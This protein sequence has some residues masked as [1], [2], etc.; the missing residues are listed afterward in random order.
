MAQKF[1][2]V[3]TTCQLYK[4][5]ITISNQAEEQVHSLKCLFL[6]QMAE[7]KDG[8]QDPMVMFENLC[9][10]AGGSLIVSYHEC[11]RHDVPNSPPAT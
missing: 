10:N 3:K 6:S 7:L 11:T 4:N 5:A 8:L 1:T 9:R 2:A